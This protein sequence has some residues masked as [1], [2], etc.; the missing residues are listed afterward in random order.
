MDETGSNSQVDRLRDR[1]PYANPLAGQ[2]PG[3]CSQAETRKAQSTPRGTAVPIWAQ[4][5]CEM[6]D[7]TAQAQPGQDTPRH[8]REDRLT[9]AKRDAL[10]RQEHED[11]EGPGTHT[12]FRVMEPER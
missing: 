4:H 10:H 7:L 3:S 12:W 9:R 1:N 2:Q 8:V 5:G 11:P 6:G